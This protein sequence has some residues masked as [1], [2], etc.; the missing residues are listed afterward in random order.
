MHEKPCLI[1]LWA[2]TQENH[3]SVVCEQQR[4]RPAFP[5]AQTDQRL[6]YSLFG[7]YHISKLATSKMSVFYLFSVAEGTG[8]SPALL[9]TPKTGFL[10]T[11]PILFHYS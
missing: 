2:S 9:E 3:S 7:K 8:L 4:G 5:S 11:R 1:L 6:C 10:A